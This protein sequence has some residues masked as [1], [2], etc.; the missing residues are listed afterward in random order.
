MT[1]DINKASVKQLA[2]LPGIGTKFAEIIVSKRAKKG[3]VTIDD[4]HDYPTLQTKL[5]ELA[6]KNLISLD[7]AE[8]LLSDPSSTDSGQTTLSKP[9]DEITRPN[10]HV[11]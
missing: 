5:N 3:T 1:M 8:S 11:D 6:E 9:Q 4:F 7:Y 10:G 2:T